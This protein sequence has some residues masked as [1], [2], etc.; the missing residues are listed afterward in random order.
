MSTASELAAL[1]WRVDSAARLSNAIKD[2]Q[3][4]WNLGTPLIVDG[5]VGPKTT[6]ALKRSY[7]NLKA[8]K[9]TASANFSFS[10]FACKCNGKYA[11]CARIHIYAG[12]IK[13]LESYRTRLGRP[14]SIVSGY[15]CPSHNR[16]VG[17]ATSSQHMYGVATDITGYKV[18]SWV[19]N[20]RLFAGLGYR[21]SNGTVV[22]V[23]SRDLSV[24]NTTHSK[25]AAPAVWRYAT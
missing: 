1:G 25:P 13:R 17:G 11:N 2:F 10:E 24:N 18:T 9:G 14:V 5:I 23:D 20:L 19:R 21:S 22:H 15:R 4:G 16:A 3:R 8:G 7:A 6:T 12:H